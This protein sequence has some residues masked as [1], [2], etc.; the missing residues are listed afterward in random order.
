MGAELRR[1]QYRDIRMFE[2]LAVNWAVK[3]E[4]P[5]KR[6]RVAAAASKANAVD[7]TTDDAANSA[8]GTVG[9]VADKAAP[10]WM[11]YQM[12]MRGHTGYL[13]VASKAAPIVTKADV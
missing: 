5:P 2:T 4:T 12:P 9:N 6:R 10:S 7:A 8:V 1:H 11:S 13:M 3:A